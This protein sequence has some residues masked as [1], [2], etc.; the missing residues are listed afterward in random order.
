M[1][2]QSTQ[3][4]L[5]EK[6]HLLRGLI[7]SHAF[8]MTFAINA[9]CRQTGYTAVFW[10]VSGPGDNRHNSSPAETSTSVFISCRFQLGVA[11]G[12]FV[13]KA[14]QGRSNLVMSPLLKHRGQEQ[15]PC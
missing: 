7:P 4:S 6:L 9:R 10:S 11:A 12:A 5:T 3:S 14:K 1:S 8:G 15:T 2:T 13:C